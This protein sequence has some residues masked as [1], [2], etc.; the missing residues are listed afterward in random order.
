[1]A[2]IIAP[3][4]VT[5]AQ[6]AR[7]PRRRSGRRFNNDELSLCLR[8][9]AEKN[10]NGVGKTNR[11]IAI[12]LGCRPETVQNIRRQYADTT[13]EALAIMRAG[14]GRAAQDWMTANRIAASEGRHQPAKEHLEA[15]GVI[16]TQRAAGTGTTVVVVGV[17]QGP[18]GNDPWNVAVNTIDVPAALP[19]KQP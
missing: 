10:I 14:A 6:L 9:L 8:L 4:H 17:G 18:V 11:Q 16:Q 3:V 5:D 12:V 7:A 15:V 13:V 2:E 1:M 19:E